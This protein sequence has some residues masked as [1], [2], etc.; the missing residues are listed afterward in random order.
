MIYA[1]GG[2]K[3]GDKKDADDTACHLRKIAR[4]G[5][6]AVNNRQN[7]ERLLRS[8]LSKMPAGCQYPFLARYYRVKGGIFIEDIVRQEF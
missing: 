1:V 2:R 7:H 5:A 6:I 3:I 4:R 8:H